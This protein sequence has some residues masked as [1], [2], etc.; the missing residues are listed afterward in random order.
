MLL[1][2]IWTAATVVIA[3]LTCGV[4]WDTM[5]NCEVC[6][7]SINEKEGFGERA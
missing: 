4:C 2:V 1:N 6:H 7:L 3:V 5:T